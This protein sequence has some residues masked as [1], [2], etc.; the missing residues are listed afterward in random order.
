MHTTKRKSA[1]KA[2]NILWNIDPCNTDSENEATE[3]EELEENSDSDTELSDTENEE[4]ATND[5]EIQENNDLYT[6]KD[7]TEWKK[8][9][10]WNDSGRVINQ[11]IFTTKPGIK[12]FAVK[13]V[14]S[15]ISSWELLIKP[16]MLEDILKFTNEYLED[17]E[18]NESEKIELFELRAFIGL[19]YLRGVFGLRKVH[20]SELWSFEFGS[21]FFRKTMARNKF[22]RIMKFIRFDSK[23]RR[24][25]HIQGDL[26]A[27]FRYLNE[28][29]TSNCKQVYQPYPSLTIDEQ[30][31]PMRNRCRFIQYMPQK[32][33]KFGIKFW[34]MVDVQTNFC[35]DYF[36]YLGA[37]EDRGNVPLGEYV[38][39]KLAKD[40]VNVGYNITTDNFFSNVPLAKYLFKKK[41]TF[42]G[43]VR[44]SSRSL[45]GEMN[46]KLPLYQSLFFRSEE[47]LAV[48][49][50]AKANKKVNLISTMHSTPVII[51]DSKKKTDAIIYYNNNKV[52]VDIMDSMLRLYSCKAASRR[53]PMGTFYD[54]LD[55]AALNSW[56]L[57]NEAIVQPSKTTRR[58]FIIT[59]A[60]ELCEEMI[61]KR[62]VSRISF[63]T[64]GTQLSNM[65][66]KRCLCAAQGCKNKTSTSCIDC[67][68]KVCGNHST[69][70][71]LCENCYNYS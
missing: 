12:T 44:A 13:F 49:Y 21:E 18:G 66:M 27:P 37:S 11:N 69:K 53:W 56:I 59:L 8:L 52:G 6:S 31:L 54:L 25:I 30:L 68:K 2:L 22:Q 57:Y 35:I 46:K 43:T 1:R 64:F 55:K 24:H 3:D 29:F 61:S 28:A 26:Y 50:Q 10:S 32:P 40:Y 5:N 7:G 38:V 62:A 9:V 65:N 41:T 16:R 36:P 14:S 15:P 48:S 19:V 58:Q 63:Q 20:P 34:A 4:E 70:I 45:I 42:V 60:Q 17:V 33:D 47:C 67:K 23:R 39:K 71:C 51:D